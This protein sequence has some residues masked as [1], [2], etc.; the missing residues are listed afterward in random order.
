[1]KASSNSTK[2]TS[3]S[4]AVQGLLEVSI[5]W[6]LSLLLKAV[7]LVVRGAIAGEERCLQN[8]NPLT[9]NTAQSRLNKLTKVSKPQMYTAEMC[10]T[11]RLHV[12]SYSPTPLPTRPR[13][14][15]KISA[16]W[17]SQPFWQEAFHSPFFLNQL[18]WACWG[19]T[20]HADVD[21]PQW[22]LCPHPFKMKTFAGSVQTDSRTASKNAAHA[23]HH[24]TSDTATG[25]GPLS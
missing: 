8:I 12:K 15:A 24:W 2:N 10:N 22:K 1:M 19:N 23:Q 25:V 6:L 17:V 9:K 14:S 13:V 20:E 11:S 5:D 21:V 3:E 7:C 18:R 16:N 4:Y